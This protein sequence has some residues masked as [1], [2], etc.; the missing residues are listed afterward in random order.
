MPNTLKSLVL[1]D[2]H[3]P[4]G[5]QEKAAGAKCLLGLIIFVLDSG[6]KSAPVSFF[7]TSFS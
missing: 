5:R 2:H 7:H 3:H 1:E 6:G 4:Q